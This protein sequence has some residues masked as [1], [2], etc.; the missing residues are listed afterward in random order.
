MKTPKPRPIKKIRHEIMQTHIILISIMTVIMTAVS[1]AVSVNSESRRLDRN[2]ENMAQAVAGSKVVQDALSGDT[3]Q[4]SL[5]KTYLDSLKDSLS[6][7][8]VISVVGADGVRKYHTNSTLIGTVY[9]GTVPEFDRRGTFY[10]SGDTGPSGDQR[11]AYCII[12][13]STGNAAG[14]VLTVMLRQ[15][16]NRVIANTA[17]VHI[18]AAAV[19]LLA[20]GILSK[21]LSGRIKKLLL[22]YEPDTFSAMF[23]LRDNIL[24]SLEEGILAFDTGENVIYCNSAARKMLDIK[25]D[26][27]QKISGIAGD[28]PVSAT[29]SQGEKYFGISFKTD[30]AADIIAD[31]I[32]VT[33]RGSV[34]GGLCILRDRTEFTKLME[35]LSGVRYMVDSMR[36]SNHDFNNKLHVILGLIQMGNNE[37]A[38]EYIGSCTARNQ[39]VMQSIIKSIEDPTVAALLIGKWQRAGELGITFTLD[40]GSRLSRS[41]ILLPSGDLVTVIGNLL[42]NA[43]DSMNESDRQPKELTVGIFTQPHVMVI[44]VDDTGGGISPENRRKIFEN[45]FSTKGEGRGTGLHL[46]N[47][48]VKRYSGSIDIE[49]EENVGTSFTVTLTDERRGGNV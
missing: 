17:A 25:S 19:V 1:V 2:L 14:F 21:H 8:D 45:G 39:R 22:G 38:I 36:A 43:M 41:D 31:I 16:I 32:P 13:D 44:T 47:S 11:R 40:K 30:K 18:C 35:D 10:V 29:I 6:G 46:V 3:G 12:Y 33:E 37:E 23:S 9:D 49:S 48:L 34:T 42:D 26:R 15:N 4:V 24:E 20:A 7:V 5:M 27:G 28:L